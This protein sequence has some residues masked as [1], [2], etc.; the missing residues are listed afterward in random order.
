V[1]LGQGNAAGIWLAIAAA[2][3]RLESCFCTANRGTMPARSKSLRERIAAQIA[4]SDDQVFLK[5]EFRRLGCDRHVGRAL[6][7]LVDEGQLIRLGYGVYGRA[8]ISRLSGEPI[9]AAEGGFIGASRQALDKLGVAWEPTKAQRAYNEGRSTQVPVN[10]GVRV[11][12]SR[13]TRK[14]RHQ[15]YEL[16]M[17][18]G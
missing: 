4:R 14:L 16:V 12:K 7:Q 2:A 6:R 15:D 8:I 9:L 1:T 13:I 3:D 5:R 11:V 10:P 18:R 17:E